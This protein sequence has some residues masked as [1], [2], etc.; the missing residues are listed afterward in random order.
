MNTYA[1]RLLL[2]SG[3]TRCGLMRL[4]AEREISA[5]HWM[6]R[7]FDAVV[8]DI[9]KLPV[10]AA[11]LLCGV[12]NIGNRSL[13][14]IELSGL[15]RDLSVMSA[16]G[17][18]LIDALRSIAADDAW[19]QKR[20][21]AT[22]RLLLS[23]LDAGAS[24]S[25]AFRHCPDIFPESVIN[26]VVIGEQTGTIDRMLLE[27]AE[28][29]ERIT[30]LRRDA[31]QA[32]IY[33]AFVFLSMLGAALFWVYYV[34]PNLA[35]LFTQMHLK[36]P[37]ITT[38]VLAFSKW[39]DR[40]A[41]VSLTLIA[42][43]FIGL[44]LLAKLH[45]RARHFVYRLAH[46]LPIAR[47]IITSSGMAFITEHL[48]ILIGAGVDIIRSL[49]VIERSVD[50]EYYRRR[51]HRARMLVERG[52]LLAQALRQAGGFPPMA[53]RMIS[54]GE[55]AGSLDRQLKH[56]AQEYRQRLKHVIAT[57]TELIKPAIIL[58]AGILFILLVIALLLPIY[59]LVR[60]A[61][62]LPMR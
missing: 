59:D 55:E 49:S 22:A 14:S 54:A 27:A 10:W 4:V 57:L 56:L 5:K 46:H 8:L 31:R 62:M 41:F 52:S 35:D 6:E 32:L 33:P 26:L 44:W 48:A 47:T 21:A 38:A 3:R 58:F 2:P 45:P 34:I 61:S 39:L 30:Y 28:H 37:A 7:H 53:L 29:I 20:I 40:H 51:I 11:T 12:G 13:P 18:P 9:H 15:L 36:V 50:D 16:A 23:E 25:E 19:E 42:T 43:M 60:Q 17:I 1:Y 24:I